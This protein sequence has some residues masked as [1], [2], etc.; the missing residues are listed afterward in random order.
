MIHGIAGIPAMTPGRV[1]HGVVWAEISGYDTPLII[2][3]SKKTRLA[4][5]SPQNSRVVRLRILQSERRTPSCTPS[6]PRTTGCCEAQKPDLPCSSEEPRPF[7][8]SVLL[9]N[10]PRISCGD[11]SNAHNPTFPLDL[12]RPPAACAC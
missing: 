4:M 6:H 1:Y 12:K 8:I 11:C 9:P 5:T 7:P 10:G 3:N 2:R